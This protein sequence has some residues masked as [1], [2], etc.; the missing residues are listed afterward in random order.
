MRFN[1]SALLLLLP[2][3]G[4]LIGL[5]TGVGSL[6]EQAFWSEG[7]LSLGNLEAFVGRP[8]AMSV[9]IYTHQMAAIVTLVCLF[10]GYPLA[11]F[12]AKRS[13]V[14]FLVLLILP[15]L[16]S[17]VVRTYGWIV[18]LG[19][20]GLI[21][22]SLLGAGVI[23]APLRL[24][25]NNGGVVLGLVHVFLPFAV[26]SILTVY[27]KIDKSLAEASMALG[28]SPLRTFLRVTLPLSMPGVIAAA[29]IV[30]LLTLGAIVTPLL[31]GSPRQMMLGSMIYDQMLVLY[32]FPR[33]AAAAIM[34]TLSA[35]L[36][37]IPLQLLD[38]WF[39]RRLPAARG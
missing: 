14:V 7:S 37:V 13:Q 27:V 5:A 6:L 39:S 3:I 10:V 18:I 38:R 29:T 15:L 25:F 30:Y 35:L 12:M 28:A 9:F 11:V 22:A 23:D 1:R 34:L 32:N 17:V 24:M 26:I 19:P 31:L 36:A 8:D 33:A 4:L 20:R 21:N 2:C 16:I